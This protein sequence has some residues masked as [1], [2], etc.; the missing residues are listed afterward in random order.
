MTRMRL[1]CLSALPILLLLCSCD[2]ADTWRILMAPTAEEGVEVSRLESSNTGTTYSIYVS[3]PDSYASGT[4]SAYPVLLLL[5][6]DAHF[7]ET[8]SRALSQCSDGLMEETVIVG[9]GYGAGEDMRN[10][11]YTP[12]SLPGVTTDGGAASGGASAF[13]AF[14]TDELLPWTEAR[15][16][17]SADRARRGIIGHSHGGL[18]ALYA[19][20][21]GSDDFGLFISASPTLTWDGLVSFSYVE[22]W[23]ASGRSTSVSLFISSSA[24]DGFPA[25]ALNNAMAEHVEAVSATAPVI[26]YYPNMVHSDVWRTAF[27]DGMAALLPRGAQ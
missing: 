22:E 4:E 8:R 14:I 3:L 9:I 2:L 26:G 21:H 5:D 10:R 13:L 24:G 18:F 19:L 17:V 11:D 12:T 20:F 15:Y 6:G 16:R 1:G 25:D 7:T 23:R 27:A